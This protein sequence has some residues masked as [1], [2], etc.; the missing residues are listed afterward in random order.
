MPP[1][2]PS[3]VYR[4]SCRYPADVDMPIMDFCGDGI[5]VSFVSSKII[6]KVVYKVVILVFSV[7]DLFDS[8]RAPE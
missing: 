1:R 7:Y 3:A 8:G 2:M 5:R 4:G 6:Y